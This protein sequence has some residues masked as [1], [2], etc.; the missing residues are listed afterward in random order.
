M[1][2]D[3]YPCQIDYAIP[4]D[5]YNRVHLVRRHAGRDLTIVVDGLSDN[6]ITIGKRRWQCWN[7]RLGK[8]LLVWSHFRPDRRRCL[9]QAVE[10]RLILQHAYSRTIIYRVH[11]GLKEGIRR[12]ERH[13]PTTTSRPSAIL[14]WPHHA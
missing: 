4:A 6:I 12:Y 1:K 2:I 11:E 10:C 3:H 8:L 7:R 13:C 5:C 14:D 9:D